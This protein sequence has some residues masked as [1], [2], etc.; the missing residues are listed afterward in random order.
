MH[1]G[2]VG[3][4]SIWSRSVTDKT[5]MPCPPVIH[6]SA[7]DV[8]RPRVTMLPARRPRPTTRTLTVRGGLE[9][10]LEHPTP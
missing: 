3:P 5:S 10:N 2:A 1:Y 7:P 4:A 9:V 6:S 8:G